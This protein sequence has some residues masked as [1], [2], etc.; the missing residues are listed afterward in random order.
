MGPESG[1]VLVWGLLEGE[2]ALVSQLAGSREVSLCT[3]REGEL[4]MERVAAGSEGLG[5]GV[6]FAREEERLPELARILG[7]LGILVNPKVRF[8]TTLSA[9]PC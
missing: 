7:F 1:R 9:R 5:Q 2:A 4:V 6:T 8:G 3:V